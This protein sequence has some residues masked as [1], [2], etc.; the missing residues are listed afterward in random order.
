MQACGLGLGHFER[1]GAV[2]H[3]AW[4]Y[5]IAGRLRPAQHAGRVTQAAL[6]SQALAG[7]FEHGD[8]LGGGVGIQFVSAG[9]VAHQ[10]DARNLAAGQQAL[11]GVMVVLGVQADAVHAAVQLQPNGERLVQLGFL[12][13]FQLPQRVHH[14][15]QVVL[16]DQRQLAGFEEAF[17]Q[18]HRGLDT[19]GAQLQRLFDASHGKT[20]GLLLKRQGATHGA[21]TVGI[22]LDHGQGFGTGQF[23]GKLIVVTQGL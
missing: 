4:A 14:A 5:P 11:V 19:G 3:Q 2:Q 20:I 13:G 23:A 12:D 22:G 10:H 15:P 9:K 6:G 18:Q 16:G 7:G 21:M 1:R 8:L 17:Q